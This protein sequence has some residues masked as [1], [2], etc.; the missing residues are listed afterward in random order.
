GKET[1]PGRTARHGRAAAGRVRRR[2]PRHDDRRRGRHD[3]PGPDHPGPD[4]PD[5]GRD[6]DDGGNGN[7]NGDH[8]GRP[9]HPGA[10]HH[11]PGRHHRRGG[12]ATVPDGPV[13]GRLRAAAGRRRH[14]HPAGR[15]HPDQRQHARLQPVRLGQGD[16]ARQGLGRDARRGPPADA[17]ARPHDAAGGAGHQGLPR[18]DFRHPGP[19][20]RAAVR[21]AG[22]GHDRDSGGRRSGVRALDGRAA[23]RSRR[24]ALP[25]GRRM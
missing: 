23:V 4:D 21:R 2:R 20:H 10:E 22:V 13:P 19:G 17:A 9:D 25:A 1:G 5:P 8:R 12:V 15:D 3:D 14:R 6:D 18:H 16:H 11:P 7:G 24:P